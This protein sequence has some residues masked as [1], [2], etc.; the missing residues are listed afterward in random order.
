MSNLMS[1]FLIQ[2][3]RQKMERF[4]LVFLSLLFSLGTANMLVGEKEGDQSK[5]IYLF[6]KSISYE[7]HLLPE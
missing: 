5:S 1:I 6:R 7:D 3:V 2:Q 4:F